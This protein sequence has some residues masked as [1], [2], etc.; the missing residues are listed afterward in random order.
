MNEKDI[1]DLLANIGIVDIEEREGKFDEN[2]Y[3][4]LRF[5]LLIP[6]SDDYAVIYSLIDG[7]EDAELKDTSS[8]CSEHLTVM[9]YILPQCRISLNANFDDNYYSLV[10]EAL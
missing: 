1:I 2:I 3:N 9:T 10:V 7:Y 4:K 8:M 6:N 5:T